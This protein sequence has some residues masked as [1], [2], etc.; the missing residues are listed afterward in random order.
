MALFGSSKSS[1]TKLSCFGKLPTYGD[2]L[3]LNSDRAGAQHI[4]RWLQEAV[5]TLRTG[6]PGPVDQFIRY[7]WPVPGSRRALVGVLWPSADAA[8]RRFPITLFSEIPSNLLEKHG[9]LRVIA[10]EPVWRSIHEVHGRLLGL[11]SANEQYKAMHDAH[12]PVPLTVEEAAPILGDRMASPALDGVPRG[13]LALHVQELAQ[14]AAG[15]A[16]APPGVEFA[17]RARLHGSADPHVEACA[18]LTILDHLS[19]RRERPAPLFLRV[20]PSERTQ[21][22]IEY[23]RDITVADLGFLLAPAPG[24]HS[25]DQH[26]FREIP[27]SRPEM[28]FRD[29]F[30]HYWGSR[31]AA[32]ETLVELGSRSWTQAE[33]DAAPPAQVAVP[34]QAAP[35]APDDAANGITGPTSMDATGATAPVTTDEDLGEEITGEIVMDAPEPTTGAVTGAL[36]ED[37]FPEPDPIPAD[38]VAPAAFDDPSEPDSVPLTTGPVV[39]AP[40]ADSDDGRYSAVAT[41]ARQ[42]EELLDEALLPGHLIPLAAREAPFGKPGGFADRE[43]VYVESEASTARVLDHGEATRLRIARRTELHEQALAL[44]AEIRNAHDAIVA[45]L[46]GRISEATSRGVNPL[47]GH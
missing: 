33:I 29:A 14:F 11:S 42:V 18:W 2:F 35:S 46:E 21:S 25:M 47:R 4:A 5:G 40:G 6:L 32:C 37:S 13:A 27:A 34:A 45:D 36:A 44:V 10:A 20:S 19:G 8:G 15:L 39:A 43:Y 30:V 28:R 1:A 17:V 22:V 16:D 9:P 24:A 7:V 31:P 38:E 26:G 41:L 12:L 3:S 23:H